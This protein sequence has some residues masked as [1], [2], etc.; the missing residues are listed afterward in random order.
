MIHTL[1]PVP[2]IRGTQSNLIQN[3]RYFV[4]IIFK[5]EVSHQN[6]YFILLSS[7]HV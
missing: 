1:E 7:F 4:R 5:V 6:S 2:E 3:N